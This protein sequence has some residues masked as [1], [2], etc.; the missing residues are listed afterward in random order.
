MRR[1][2]EEMIAGYDEQI[3]R[4]RARR[5]AAVARYG[6]EERRART[7]ALCVMGGMIE[8]CFEH[9]WKSVDWQGL[10]LL[11]ESNRALFAQQAAEALPT[12]DASKRL[13]QWEHESRKVED[14]DEESN[15]AEGR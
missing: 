7:H 14:N 13:R 3:A 5:H 6:K 1:S 4:I 11:I 9:G 12:A 10:D 15:T 8:K 2:Y